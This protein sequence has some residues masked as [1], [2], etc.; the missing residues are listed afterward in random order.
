MQQLRGL[1]DLPSTHTA[2]YSGLSVIP[3]PGEL[4]PSSDSHRDQAH[5]W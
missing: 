5:M 3:V 4:I 1:T 2:A